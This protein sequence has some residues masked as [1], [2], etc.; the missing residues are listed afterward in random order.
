[1]DGSPNNPTREHELI[2]DW[3]LAGSPPKYESSIEFDDETLRDGLQSPSVTQPGIEDKIKLLHLMADLG[4]QSADIGLPGAGKHATRDVIA[5]A[6]EIAN[7]KLPIAPNCAARTLVAD[8][9]P[10]I[11]ASQQS[12]ISLEASVFIGS[13]PIREYVEDWTLDFM[14]ECSETAVNYAIKNGLTVMFVTEDTTRARPDVLKAL[15]STAIQCGARRIC[16]SDTVGHA[17]PHGARMLVKFMKEV[18]KESGEE[19]MI[20]WHGHRDRALGMENALAAAEAGANRL[21][22]TALGVG[23]RCGNVPMEHLLVN[24]KLLGVIDNDLTKLSEYCELVSK[25]CNVPISFGHPVIGADAYRTSTGVHA[26]AVIKALKTKD[27]WLINRVYSG[28]PADWTGR[29]QAIEIGPMSGA[30]NVIY[31]LQ[32]RGIEPTET[33]VAKIFDTAKENKRVMTEE[34]V[35]GIVSTLVG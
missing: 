29:D 12:G 32:S 13:S 34:E 16:L 26:A 25:T 17:N 35:Y 1:M 10:I 30:S 22:G 5:L 23:E 4:I 6:K 24:L 28:V 20:D 8:I 15:Y 19:V 11:E 14:R 7:Q 18:V 9:D 27:T 2:H 31:W 21:H 33:L 3:N